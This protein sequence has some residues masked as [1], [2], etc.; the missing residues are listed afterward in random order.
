VASKRNAYGSVTDFSRKDNGSVADFAGSP[1]TEVG[2]RGLLV[3]LAGGM[4][5]AGVFGTVALARGGAQPDPGAGISRVDLRGVNFV[6]NC[7]FSHRAPDDPIV[8]PGKPGASHEHTFV[9][10]RS[11]NAFSTYGS[12]RA[13]GT[14]CERADDTAAYWVPTVYQGTTAIPP[15][16]AT[17]YYRRGTLAPV[18]TLP[19]NLR[20][21]AGDATATAAQTMRVTFWSCGVAGGL[22]PSSTV[23]TCPATRRSFL[24][25]HVRFP[26]CWNGRALDSA[27]HK[28]HMA[29][30]TRRGC[31]STHPISVPAITQIYRYPTRGGEGFSLAS[32]G[33]FSAHADFLNAW[34]PEALKALVDGCL[35]ALVHCGRG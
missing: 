7:R 5:V 35:N 11:T 8:F 1:R 26:N 22:P 9:G 30:A 17:I 27:D 14:T 2:V 31:P 21:I 33:Q 28:G 20:M 29:Y 23:P 13:S 10:N 4:L 34:E 15:L 12:L 32:G 16:A 18:R 3:I 6:E 24:R 19:D 25:L